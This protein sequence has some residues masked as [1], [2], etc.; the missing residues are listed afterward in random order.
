MSFLAGKF[1]YSMTGDLEAIDLDKREILYAMNGVEKNLSPEVTLNFRK[2]FYSSELYSPSSNLHGIIKR[3]LVGNGIDYSSRL[4]CTLQTFPLFLDL[5]SNQKFFLWRDYICGSLDKLPENFFYSR[6]FIHPSGVSYAFLAIKSK[7]ARFSDSHWIDE[8]LNL[9]K[10]S[11]FSNLSINLPNPYNLIANFSEKERYF[12]EEEKSYFIV[13]DYFVIHPRY[14]KDPFYGHYYSRN[15]GHFFHFYAKKNVNTFLEQTPFVISLKKGGHKC[16]IKQ[17]NLCVKYSLRYYFSYASKTTLTIL[18]LSLLLLVVVVWKF[19]QRIREEKEE[20]E[21]R[22]L[23]LQILTHEFRT[24]I[25][26]LVLQNELVSKHIETLPE[27]MSDT[28]MDISSNVFRL[29]RLAEMSKNYL[30]AS[31]QGDFRLNNAN[32]DSA[33]SVIQSFVDEFDIDDLNVTWLDEDIH[34]CVDLFWMHLCLKNLIVNAVKYGKP[35]ILLKLSATEK[36]FMIAVCDQGECISSDLCE[37][38]TE[39]IKDESSEGIG[40]GLNIVK[41]AMKGVGGEL[42]FSSKPT[43]FTL[44]FRNVVKNEN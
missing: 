19:F 11:E 31:K 1:F 13:G 44:L 8:H 18:V 28:F 6:P 34:L 9:F 12:F 43:T 27:D 32:I 16:L 33:N 36:N 23:A 38:T 14:S 25:A 40:L 42:R 3:S 30:L 26:A 29:Q 21:N 35:P 37:L 24:P 7:I 4:S 2:L 5:E 10:L 17:N 39:F 15:T 22:R 20:Q 41:R